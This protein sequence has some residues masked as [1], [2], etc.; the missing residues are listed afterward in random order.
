MVYQDDPVAYYAKHGESIQRQTN[1]A[2]EQRIKSREWLVA[3]RGGKC[4]DCGYNR[5]ISVLQFDHI[6]PDTKYTEMTAQLGLKPTPERLAW[7]EAEAMKCELRCANCHWERTLREGH[8]GR[9]PH[10]RLQR[11][12][13]RCVKSGFKS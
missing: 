4:V 7:L 2:R 11:A 5:N 9:R 13:G 10:A 3:L 6:D 12:I 1:K 8:I